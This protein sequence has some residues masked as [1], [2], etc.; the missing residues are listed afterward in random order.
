M[1]TGASSGLPP[2][3]LIDLATSG[4]ALQQLVELTLLTRRIASRED[5]SDADRQQMSRM[6]AELLPEARRQ[7]QR[8]H[9][10]F[11]TNQDELDALA[12]RAEADGCSLASRTT[13]DFGRRAA[14]SAARLVQRLAANERD[15]D[16]EGLCDAYD[17]LIFQDDVKCIEGSALACA[18][19]QVWAQLAI[20]DGCL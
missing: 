9:T 4:N 18:S 6:R 7:A 16:D 3:A 13:G 11:E 10:F 17:T 20:E 2:G 15:D 8:L 1:P 14:A 5:A 19:G 12:V